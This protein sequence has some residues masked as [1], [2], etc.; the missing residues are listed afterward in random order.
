MGI[1]ILY[2]FLCENI[3]WCISFPKRSHTRI[4]RILTQT[5]SERL[6]TC[7]V[8][9]NNINF[10]SYISASDKHLPECINFV[11]LLMVGRPK[12]PDLLRVM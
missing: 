6:C 7:K 1:N 11:T 3:F 12:V 10:S 2:F 4:L 9:R 5:G 8:N